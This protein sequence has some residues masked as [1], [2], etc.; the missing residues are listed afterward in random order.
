MFI[1]N[2]IRG[3]TM[4]LA[5]SVPGV[6]G[7]TIAFLFGF[8]DQFVGSIDDIFHGTKETRK[9][10]CIFIIK[11]GLGWLIGMGLAV[12]VLAEIFDTQIYKISSLFIG[13][14][15]CS[16]PVIIMEE[17]DCLKDRKQFFYIIIGALI[18]MA[19]TYFNP[20]S[21][22]GNSF[23]ISD[24]T[25]GFAIYVFV[26]AMLAISAMVLPG[27]SGSTI[28]LVFGLYVPIIT[29]L[30]DLLHFQFEALPILIIFGFGV[31]AGVLVVIRLIRNALEHYRAQMVYLIIGMMIGSFYAI[32]MGPTT[33]K[34][35]Q[36]AINFSTF[37]IIF[38]LIGAAIVILLQWSKGHM[39]REK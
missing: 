31:I 14:I 12:S 3:F 19:I 33:L 29:A 25:I 36:A 18:V 39:S 32:I 27:I 17:K 20:V 21:S 2:F 15:A 34:V 1:I 10:G 11:L 37:H 7:G 26:A 23:A 28:L 35:P 24:L 4:A 38:F 9:A 16:I 13:F 30:K 5:D 22:S 8:Y 6:S